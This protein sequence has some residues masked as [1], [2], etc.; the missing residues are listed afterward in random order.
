[1]K[2][3]EY[4]AIESPSQQDVTINE[5]GVERKEIGHER[6]EKSGSI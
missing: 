6:F 1:M 5:K 2:V 3:P 4:G